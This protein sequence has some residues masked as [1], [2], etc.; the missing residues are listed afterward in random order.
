MKLLVNKSGYNQR[1]GRTE[2]GGCLVTGLGESQV[3]TLKRKRVGRER[4][5]RKEEKGEEGGKG[6]E[7]EEEKKKEDGENVRSPL[8][9]VD[10]EQVP[11]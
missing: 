11:K 8:D 9:V 3:G 4:R 2:V 1:L 5:R 10:Q 6:E 7:E